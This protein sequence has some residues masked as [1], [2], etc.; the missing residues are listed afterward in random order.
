MTTALIAE[1]SAFGVSPKQT[2][3][4]WRRKGV[5]AMHGLSHVSRSEI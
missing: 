1:D 3:L 2:A 4:L 5:Q